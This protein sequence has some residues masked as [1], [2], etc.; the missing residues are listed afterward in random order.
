LFRCVCR[1]FEDAKMFGVK[2][3]RVVDQVPSHDN[4]MQILLR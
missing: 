3:A 1:R 4:M 2:E